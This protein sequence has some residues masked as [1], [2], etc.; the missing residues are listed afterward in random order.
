MSHTFGF[1]HFYLTTG[2][3]P[4]FPNRLLSSLVV[5][6]RSLDLKVMHEG[7]FLLMFNIETICYAH[8]LL[9]YFTL[10]NR[11]VLTLQVNMTFW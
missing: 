4:Y 6:V 7:N 9:K 1:Q 5:Y 11:H 8:K 10:F 2:K 3:Q